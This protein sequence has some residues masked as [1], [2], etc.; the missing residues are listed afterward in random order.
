MEMLRWLLTLLVCLANIIRQWHVH[1]IITPEHDSQS[2]SLVDTCN[3]VNENV[4]VHQQLRLCGSPQTRSLIS[5]SNKG[6]IQGLNIRSAFAERAMIS[7]VPC[8]LSGWRS[9]ILTRSNDDAAFFFLGTHASAHHLS[10]YISQFCFLQG[11]FYIAKVICI[12][13][14]SQSVILCCVAL[15]LRRHEQHILHKYIPPQNYIC[16]IPKTIPHN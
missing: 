9:G 10:A 16:W 5:S 2:V 4:L 6:S 1:Y 8:K 13:S 15:G 11:A 12:E 3:V 7:I 14:C